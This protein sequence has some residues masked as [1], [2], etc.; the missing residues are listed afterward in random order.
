MSQNTFP[1]FTDMIPTVEDIQLIVDALRQEDRS[2]TTKDGIFTPGIVNAPDEYLQKGSSADG[3]SLK[4]KP[5][6]AYTAN[7]DRIEVS[8]TWDYLYPQGSVIPVSDANKVSDYKDIPVWYPY[9]ISFSNLTSEELTENI[10]IIELGR[11]SVLHGIKVRANVAFAD[12]VGSNIYISIGTQ[13]EPEKF[14]PPTSISDTSSGD[15]SAMNLMY[16]LS[17][18][19]TTPIIVTFTSDSG[20][21]NQLTNGNVLINFCIANLSGF[22]N[23]EL[24]LTNGGYEISNNMV[25]SWQPS[26]VYHI[27]VRYKENPSLPKQLKYTTTDGTDIT[28]TSE[29]TR[30]TTDYGFYA[31]RKTGSEI[32]STTIND[33][34]LGEVV[35]DTAGN[36]N[37]IYINGKNTTGNDY[38][39]YLTIPGYRFVDG[40][41]ANQIGDGTVSN[42]QFSYLNTLTENVQSQLNNKAS[43]NTDNIFTGINTFNEQIKGSIDKVNGFTAFATPTENSLLVLDENAKIPASAIS[44]S[45]IAS[46]GNFYTVSNGITGTNGRS[47][48]LVPNGTTGVVV[49]ASAENPLVLNYPDG[50][51]EK[52]TS[53]INVTGLS[54]SGYYYLVKEKDGNFQF[55]A[56]NGGTAAMIPIVTSGNSFWFD[57]GYGSVSKSYTNSDGTAYKAFDGTLSDGAYMGKVTYKN[58]NNVETTSYLPDETSI[59]VTFPTAITATGFALCFRKNHDDITPKAW[60]LI[61]TNDDPTSETAS[62]DDLYIVTAENPSTWNEGQIYT[63]SVSTVTAYTTFRIVFEVNETTVYNYMEGE[64]TKS[65]GITMPINCYYFQIYAI[66]TDTSAKGNI[67]EDYVKPQ[68]M[69]MGSYFLDISKKP[70]TGYKCVGNNQFEKV[71]FV[72]LGFIDLIDY[73]GSN[74]QLYCYPFCYNTFTIS[75]K[76]II[77]AQSSQNQIDYPIYTINGST[78]EYTNEI[79]LNTP[80]YFDHNLGIVPNIVDIKFLC[81]EA[82]NGYAVGDYINN[83]YSKHGSDLIS[84]KDCLSTTITQIVLKPGYPSANLYVRNKSTG[85]LGAISSNQWAAIIYCSRGW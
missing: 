58:Y 7:G 53:D 37:K 77:I 72:K 82:N 35:T 64:E 71:N 42:K 44:E 26:T 41:N 75:D 12:E 81:L 39:Q 61:A 47:A 23:S 34:K 10:K 29:Y 9:S 27:V 69:S 31:L 16:S 8:S 73:G 22:D 68:G 50:S 3:N 2:R 14:L 13:S 49:K 48:Y 5:F 70:Y 84:V 62:W 36:V 25:G 63:F 6:I 18:I 24:T 43:L 51:V 54:A 85:D 46:I 4:I 15:I 40:I 45:T 78:K 17:D 57:D 67:I 65:T 52:F 19:N 59:Q 33:V 66:N 28:T 38:T 76:E 11:G 83:I 55:L 32:D 74:P 1:A 79:V 30:Y 56:T 21:L 60:R 80:L 20:Q